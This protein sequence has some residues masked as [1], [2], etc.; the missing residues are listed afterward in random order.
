MA[1]FIAHGMA[2][3]HVH[4]SL[5]NAL[6]H[7]VW[8]VSRHALFGFGLFRCQALTDIKK[9]L[10]EAKTLYKKAKAEQYA[11]DVTRFH[12]KIET[13]KNRL[14]L[15]EIAKTDKEENKSIALGKLMLSCI[16]YSSS[17]VHCSAGAPCLDSHTRTGMKS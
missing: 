8:C 12:K 4:Y 3:V 10:K 15:K 11:K 5:T 14:H 2:Y 6:L 16:P 1:I 9:Q 7:G 13:L 17:S